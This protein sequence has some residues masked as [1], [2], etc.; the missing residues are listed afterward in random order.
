MGRPL[1]WGQ[2]K[3]GVV[4]RVPG[5]F[6]HEVRAAEWLVRLDADA[7]ATTM[8]SWQQWL[9]EDARHHAA[10]A[11]L[12]ASWRQADRLQGLRPL[13]GTVDA[14]LVD[15]FPGMRPRMRP[16]GLRWSRPWSLPAPYGEFAVAVTAGGLA[17]LLVLAGWFLLVTLGSTR[18]Q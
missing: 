9:E 5:A 12:E 15:S 13:D 17:S 8:S 4:N 3:S 6:D 16:P 14:D 7:S 18:A 2:R 1:G 11:R 10:F